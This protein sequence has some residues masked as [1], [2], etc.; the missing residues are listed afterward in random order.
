MP[1]SPRR[2]WRERIEQGLYRRHSVSC[3]ASAER[4]PGRRC[5]CPFSLIVPAAERGRTRTVTFQGTLTE[6]RNR[7]RQLLAAGRDEAPAAAPEG[8]LLRDW[9][10]AWMREGSRRWAPATIDAR[11]RAFRMRIDPRFG[12]TPLNR[13]TRDAVESWVGELVDAGQGRRSIEIALE[14]LRAMLGVALRTEQIASNPAADVHVPKDQQATGSAADRVLN[15]EELTRLIEACRN[16]YEETIVRAAAEGGLR[17]GEITGLTWPDVRLD[18]RR[19][20]IRRQVYQDSR[21][22]KIEKTTKGQVGRV[23]IS[24][25]FADL[26]G[27]HYQQSVVTGGADP[28]GWVWPGRKAGEPMSPSSITHLIGKIGRRAG[29][30]DA[31]GTHI[32]H[33]HGLRHSAGSIAL[34]EG[35]PLTVVSA[36]L[37]HSRLDTTTRTYL[38][39]LGDDHLDAFAQAHDAQDGAQTLRGTLREDLREH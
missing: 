29:L 30:V 2:G 32:A 3:P 5:S 11:D 38:H 6:A 28:L 8:R 27:E 33:L 37:R 18:E 20:L 16:L 12:D 23:A 36:Q 21:V 9:A 7:R 4:T 19:L 22:G 34:A 25:T 31:D 24:P 26:L 14:T 10:T 35:V 13:I 1:P 17:R 39:L 15:R